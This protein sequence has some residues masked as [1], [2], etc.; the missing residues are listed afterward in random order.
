MVLHIDNNS[1]EELC[2]PS[3]DELDQQIASQVERAR[4][5]DYSEHAK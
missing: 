1:E 3:D 4:L 2:F 5:N